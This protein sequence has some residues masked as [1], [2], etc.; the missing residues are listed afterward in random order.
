MLI[1]ARSVQREIQL[2]EKQARMADS[3]VRSQSDRLEPLMRA[4]FDA[5]PD[6]ERW[7]RINAMCGAMSDEFDREMKALLRPEQ[8][9][10]LTQIS[11]QNAG[12]RAL[13]MPEVADALNLAPEQREAI[14]EVLDDLAAKEKQLQGDLRREDL[15]EF[16]AFPSDDWTKFAK[17][18]P[19]L[20]RHGRVDA[21][22]ESLR[23]RA[24]REV[25]RILTGRQWKRFRQMLGPAFDPEKHRTAAD[26]PP[27]KK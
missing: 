16:D 19:Y 4:R 13:L 12:L 27:P 24:H 18:E 6:R 25:G 9:R 10:R 5:T 1:R 14:R 17:S 8:A 21:A 2:T 15:R 22:T 7:A 3:L 23:G 26:G 20:E 11:M